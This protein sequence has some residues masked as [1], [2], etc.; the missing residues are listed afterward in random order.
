MAGLLFSYESLIQD[1]F[2]STTPAEPTDSGKMS[3]CQGRSYPWALQEGLLEVNWLLVGRQVRQGSGHY[4]LKQSR[5]ACPIEGD[6]S[7][8]R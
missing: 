4:E 6:S 2:R 1:L 3:V 5:A 8:C 7:R